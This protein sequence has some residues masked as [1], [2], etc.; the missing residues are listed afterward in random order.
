MRWAVIMVDWPPPLAMLAAAA[1]LAL[2]PAAVP[3]RPGGAGAHGFTDMLY[4]AVV[5][6]GQ[7]RLGPCGGFDADAPSA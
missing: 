1:V 6:G 2:V 3:Y 7:Q 4:A 5:G